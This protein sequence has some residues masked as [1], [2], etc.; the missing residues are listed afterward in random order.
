MCNETGAA[1][2]W[3]QPPLHCTLRWLPLLERRILRIDEDAVIT[4]AEAILLEDAD[5]GVFAP[6]AEGGN[7]CGRRTVK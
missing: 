6:S 5:L 3:A 1:P 7:G 2:G 4:M